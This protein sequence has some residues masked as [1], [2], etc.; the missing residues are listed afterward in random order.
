MPDYLFDGLFL[1]LF[2]FMGAMALLA[3]C[4]GFRWAWKRLVLRVA[5]TS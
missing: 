5:R 2:L 1:G 4:V 3:L